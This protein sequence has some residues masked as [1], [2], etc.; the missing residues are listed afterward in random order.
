MTHFIFKKLKI[1][2]L[3]IF[4]FILAK[5][6][7]VSSGKKKLNSLKFNEK[8][9]RGCFFIDKIPKKFNIS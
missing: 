5:K 1:L 8:K 6:G 4:F 2:F 3:S 7:R 9:K